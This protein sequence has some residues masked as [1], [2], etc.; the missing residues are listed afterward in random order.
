MA[1]IKLV[2]F[3]TLVALEMVLQPCK[4]PPPFF[5][6]PPEKDYGYHME[7]GILK[8]DLIERGS[9]KA[10]Y[11]RKVFH[12]IYCICPLPPPLKNLSTVVNLYL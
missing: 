2:T 11:I 3:E 6:L 8:T 9:K 1:L 12:L 4:L 7:V 5:F 10:F